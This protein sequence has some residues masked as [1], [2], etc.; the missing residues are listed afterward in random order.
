MTNERSTA[1]AIEPPVAKPTRTGGAELYFLANERSLPVTPELNRP[2]EYL[3]VA[4]LASASGSASLAGTPFTGEWFKN[5]SIEVAPMRDA[6]S[7][8]RQFDAQLSTLFAEASVEPGEVH[9]AEWLLV[10]HASEPQLG[11]WLESFF[12][13]KSEY[14]RSFVICLGRLGS[15]SIAHAPALQ[16]ILR[17]ALADGSLQIREAAVRAIETLGDIGRDVLTSHD[18]RVPWLKSYAERVLQRLS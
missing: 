14:R 15:D 2:L 16:R 6:R 3:I 18:E 8:Q 4:A 11:A 9:P 7:A 13:S 12:D 1:A 10:N 5:A 17:R